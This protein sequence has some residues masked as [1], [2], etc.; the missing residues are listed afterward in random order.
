MFEFVNNLIGITGEFLG[1]IIIILGSLIIAQIVKIFLNKYTTKITKKTKTDLDDLILS[2]TTK[3]IYIGIIITGIYL[4]VRILTHAQNYLFYLDTSYF[5]IIVLLAA[6]V[7]SKITSLIIIR[8]LKVQKKYQKTPQLMS[9]IISI[10]IYI[11]A[12]LMVLAYFNVDITPIVAGLGIGGLAIGL[13]LQSTLSDFFAGLHILSDKPIRVGDYIELENKLSG[14]VEDI[15]WRSTRIRTLPN[16]IV[17]IPNSKL[18]D[19]IVTN[20]SMPQDEMGVVVQCG[21]DYSSDLEKVEKITIDVAKKIQKKIQG[22][23]KDFEPF[24]R[25]HTFGDSNI[26][27]SIILRVEKP[28]DK[29]IVT[30][31]FIKELKKR[32]DKERIEI[33]WPV[34]K[35]YQRK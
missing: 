25:Y 3:P 5:I 19:S 13:A 1:S 30:H 31:E 14:F 21:V 29:F 35:I 23:V 9:K 8:T 28:V 17:V 15:G 12:I 24:I 4:G 26:N 20:Y 34:R 10:V 18:A 32:F 22:A 2:I 7:V 16:N 33:S 27:F 6:S 11:I